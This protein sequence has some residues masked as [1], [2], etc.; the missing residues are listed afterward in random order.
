[1]TILIG[2]LTTHTEEARGGDTGGG[3][4]ILSGLSQLAPQQGD[5]TQGDS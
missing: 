4:G 3:T 1:M 5:D 2:V